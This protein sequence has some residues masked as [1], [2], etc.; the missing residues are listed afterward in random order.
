MTGT[1]TPEYIKMIRQLKK[2]EGA[3]RDSDGDHVMY[4]DA[5]G[6]VL[7]NAFAPCKGFRTIGYGHNLDAKALPE[8]LR[9]RMT[10]TEDEAEFV[11]SEDV[12]DHLYNLQREWPFINQLYL[13]NPA[14]W[15][16]CVN[17]AFNLGVPGFMKFRRTRALIEDGDYEEA[18]H[19]MQESR[20]CGQVRTRCKELAMQMLTGEFSEDHDI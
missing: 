19:A 8:S 2:H 12:Q 3:V 9:N 6:K 20:W 13:I 7:R 18:Y 11:L 15:A 16:V 1:D 4:D 5:T 14:R 17:M 10:L